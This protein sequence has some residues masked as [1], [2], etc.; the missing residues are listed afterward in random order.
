M[1]QTT[2]GAPT[3]PRTTNTNA[4]TGHKCASADAAHI[5]TRCSKRTATR[6]SAWTANAWSDL[7]ACRCARVTNDA[8]YLRAE[9]LRVGLSMNALARLLEVNQR[10]VRRWVE[11]TPL[12]YYARFVL[13]ALPTR[14]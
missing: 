5:R 1:P 6:S 11:D 14:A 4:P 7:C 3:Y 12:P 10:T 2:Y 9:L 8:D 13:A